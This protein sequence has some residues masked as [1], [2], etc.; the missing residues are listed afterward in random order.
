MTSRKQSPALA[1]LSIV[2]GLLL[3]TTGTMATN[4]KNKY[5]RDDARSQKSIIAM[6]NRAVAIEIF[7]DPTLRRHP[8]LD[9][10]LLN[11][12]KA[13]R[14]NWAKEADEEFKDNPEFFTDGRKWSADRIYSFRSQIGRYLSIVRSDTTYSGGAH[15]N[16]NIDTILWDTTL[17]KRVSVRPLF[18]ETAD[19]GPTMQALARLAR[20]AVAEAKI[21][22]SDDNAS[23]TS[24]EQLLA[25]N[26]FIESGVA[27][28][29]LGIG[30]I[31]LAPSTVAGKSS[32]LTFHYHPYAVGPYAEGPHTVFVRWQDFRD[33][34]SPNGRVL[35][36]GERPEK[37]KEDY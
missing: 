30:P 18:S 14:N 2:A 9:D 23:K 36:G 3:L 12:A 10:N 29:L 1:A 16:L 5:A 17:K 25:D 13:Y 11:E 19:N 7:I 37:D 35:F 31:T 15:G 33:Y 20:L 4:Q 26:N 6:K 27:P 24:P 21:A 28:K 32:G 34:L 8:G 22:V